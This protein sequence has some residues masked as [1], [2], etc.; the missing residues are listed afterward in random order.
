MKRGEHEVPGERRLHRDLGRLLVADLAHEDHVWIL[1]EHA[2]QDL[3]EGEVGCHV[4]GGLRDVVEAVFDRILDRDD[5]PR[6]HVD[7]ADRT[8]QGRRLARSGGAAHDQ[9]PVWPVDDLPQFLEHL[10]GETKLV[11]AL[12]DDATLGVEEAQGDLLAEVRR[13]GG[14]PDVELTSVEHGRERAVLRATPLGDVHVAEHLDRRDRGPPRHPGHGAGVLHDA[15]DP[16]PHEEFV[17]ALGFEM[18]V[19]GPQ[20]DRL[21]ENRL[22]RRDRF[23]GLVVEIVRLVA[24]VRAAVFLEQRE[25]RARRNAAAR[26][27][28]SHRTG[29][30]VPA[31]GLGHE[32]EQAIELRGKNSVAARHVELAPARVPGDEAKQ[33]GQHEVYG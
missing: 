28:G 14:G 32:P 31:A 27:S 29:P 3:G 9:H 25:P 11:E 1:P 16:V 17:A 8:I 33:G 18:N 22:G 21:R 4:H 30:T 26:R 6:E 13:S 2:P 12:L 24:V 23:R 10:V 15:V 5:V 20:L 7:L 19:G